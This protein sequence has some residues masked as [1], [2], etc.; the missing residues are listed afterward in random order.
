MLVLRRP[1]LLNIAMHHVLSKLKNEV[2]PANDDYGDREVLLPLLH[3]FREFLTMV[4][5]LL[6]QF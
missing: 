1:D 4:R 2:L 3:L 5:R 6:P